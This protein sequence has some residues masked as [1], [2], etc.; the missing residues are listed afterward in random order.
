MMAIGMAAR[1]IGQTLERETN[2]PCQVYY[3]TADYNLALIVYE[4]GK[5]IVFLIGVVSY[6]RTAI[7]LSAFYVFW[8]DVTYLFGWQSKVF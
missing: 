8:Q 2:L 6:T 3:P 7:V 1:R 4:F 5:Q